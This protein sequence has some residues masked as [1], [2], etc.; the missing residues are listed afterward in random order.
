MTLSILLTTRTHPPKSQTLPLADAL[1]FSSTHCH[2]CKGQKKRQKNTNLHFCS[3]HLCASHGWKEHELPFDGRVFEGAR[4]QDGHRRGMS[5]TVQGTARVL[6]L[7]LPSFC[8]FLPHPRVTKSICT[9]RNTSRC[10][11]LRIVGTGLA[12]VGWWRN[13]RRES[14]R[15][16]TTTRSQAPVGLKV[17][18]E[19]ILFKWWKGVEGLPALL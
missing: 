16:S 2:G 14:T 4:C 3:S 15:T 11:T 12:N 8:T 17:K 5:S 1:H 9:P 6:P 10:G 19:Y 18:V 7:G 13:P